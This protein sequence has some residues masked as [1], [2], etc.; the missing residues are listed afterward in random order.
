MSAV[1]LFALFPRGYP[2]LLM[3]IDLIGIPFLRIWA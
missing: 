1:L 2:L 3:L